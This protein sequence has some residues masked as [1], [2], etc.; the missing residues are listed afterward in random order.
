MKI[1]VITVCYNA[2]NT[3]LQTLES[4][5]EQS[6]PDIE[7]IIV[8]GASKDGTLE[9][10][11]QHAGRNVNLI[12]EADQGVYDAMNKGL[13]L[14]TGDYVG[15]L[16]ADD[17]YAGVNAVQ[18]MVDAIKST[19]AD[20]V[21]GNVQ[22][23]D[24]KNLTAIER[25]Y[26]VKRFARWWITIGIMPPHPALFVKRSKIEKTGGFDL[27]Y[28]MAADFDLIA[29]LFLEHQVTWTVVDE[30]ITLF[31]V[32]GI[33][34]RDGLMQANL[35]REFARSLSAL[36]V[37]FARTKVVCRYPVKALQFV[38][39]LLKKVRLITSVGVSL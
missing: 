2:K 11:R 33:S 16:N 5:A 19:H 15:F 38:P 18:S 13:S 12:S 25:Y 35:S 31:R 8:D 4:V 32:G 37:S 21:M 10:I 34:T 39:A 29:R 22:F 20:C 23:F 36:N 3:I 26:S 28:K 14:A 24:A 7:H 17:K 9:I 1:T 6:W 30:T 27:S